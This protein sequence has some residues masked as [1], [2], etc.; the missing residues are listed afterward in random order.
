MAQQMKGD[1]PG[2][3]ETLQAYIEHYGNSPYA[4]QAQ[5]RLAALP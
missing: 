5:K 1:V 3:K 2:A 4:A